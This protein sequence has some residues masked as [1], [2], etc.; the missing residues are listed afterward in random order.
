MGRLL[1]LWEMRGDGKKCCKSLRTREDVFDKISR[2]KRDGVLPAKCKY[3]HDERL[4]KRF[5]MS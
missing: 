4:M 3:E 2:L 1:F 5:Q